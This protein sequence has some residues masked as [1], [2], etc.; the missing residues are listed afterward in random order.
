V[1]LFANRQD[2]NGPEI[3]KMHFQSISDDQTEHVYYGEIKTDRNISDYTVRIIPCYDNIK[4][5][6]ENNLI[7]W[8]H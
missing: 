2:E 4:A 1:Q 5:P 7:L 8:Q 6:L 3:L